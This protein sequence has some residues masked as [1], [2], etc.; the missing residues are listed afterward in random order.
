MF[1]LVPVKPH[2]IEMVNIDMTIMY[3]P[4]KFF[5][6]WFQRRSFYVRFVLKKVQVGNDQEK[7]QSKKDSHSKIRGG[8][9]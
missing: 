6:L 9:H 4:W 2:F 8:K 7:A 5:A 3:T 1:S